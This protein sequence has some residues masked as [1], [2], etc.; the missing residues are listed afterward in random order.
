VILQMGDEPL[1][2]DQPEDDLENKLIRYL[3]VETLKKIKQNRQLIVSTH[4]ANVVV[5]S[6]AE[7]ILVLEHDAALPAIEASG[8]LQH[9]DVKDSVREILEGGEDAIRTRFMRL[10]GVPS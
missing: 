9:P 6:G 2:L 5:T 7:N 3:A 1:L 8:T 10:V 4:N